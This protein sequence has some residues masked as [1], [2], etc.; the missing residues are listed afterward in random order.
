L[1]KIKKFFLKKKKDPMA[2]EKCA[3]PGCSFHPESNG[4]CFRHS[5]YGTKVEKKKVPI[6]KESKKR[7]QEKKVYN[8]VKKQMLTESILCEIKSPVCTIFAQGLDHLQKRSPSNLTK[9]KNLKR[10]C[11]A[12]N[13]YKEDHP[14]WAKENG[15][16]ISRFKKTEE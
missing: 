3:F 11:N 10:A 8:K 14:E 13:T 2:N 16:S 1:K 6:P 12:C 4:Y 7:K 15:H 5:I 9:R